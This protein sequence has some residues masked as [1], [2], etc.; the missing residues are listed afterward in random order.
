[1]GVVHCVPRTATQFLPSVPAPIHSLI[2]TRQR[3]TLSNTYP[4]HNTP[5]YYILSFLTPYLFPI[6]LT[7]SLLQAIHEIIDTILAFSIT[8]PS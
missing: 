6:V 7:Y 5:L 3:V 2:K 1:M 4:F 8:Y